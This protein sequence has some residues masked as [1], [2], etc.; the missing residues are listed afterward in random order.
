M[1]YG[2]SGVRPPRRIAEPLHE[3]GQPAGAQDRQLAPRGDDR[4]LRVEEHRHRELHRDSVSDLV[5]EV[6]GLGHGRAGERDERDD[7]EHAQARMDTGVLTEIDAPDGDAGERERR[8]LD[9]R[10]VADEREDRAMMIG[11]AMDVEEPRAGGDDARRQLSD[12]E[13]VTS[14]GDVRDALEHAASASRP[15]PSPPSPP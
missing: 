2:R 3:R 15:F 13:R 11:V 10:R 14:L 5:R 9:R 7:V 1:H 4:R 6:H 8:R 12:H